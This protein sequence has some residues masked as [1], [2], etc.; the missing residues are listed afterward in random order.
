[1]EREPLGRLAVRRLI[2]RQR[3]PDEPAV[4]IIEATQL[5]VRGSCGAALGGGGARSARELSAD[6]TQPGSPVNAG[7]RG[8]AVETSGLAQ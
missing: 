7:E 2:E 8:S 3:H 1:M 6:A 5:M 4:R